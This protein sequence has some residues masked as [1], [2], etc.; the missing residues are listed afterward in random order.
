MNKGDGST[1]ERSRAPT[2]TGHASAGPSSPWAP[3][4][5]PPP[6]PVLPPQQSRKSPQT[7]PR[8][9]LAH[10]VTA[11]PK[12][13]VGQTHTWLISQVPGSKTTLTAKFVEWNLCF[14]CL[15]D[16]IWKWAKLLKHVVT[17]L[18]KSRYFCVPRH[19]ARHWRSTV[20]GR[21]I[22]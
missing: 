6:Q 15:H 1:E 17:L 7:R 2:D 4:A 16:F 3:P 8:P 11:L 9:Q 12:Y 18:H 19:G 20:E 22:I 5:M 10:P 14:K 21:P 13:D